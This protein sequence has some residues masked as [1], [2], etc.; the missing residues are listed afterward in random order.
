MERY[1]KMTHF[2]YGKYEKM[3]SGPTVKRNRLAKR[4]YVK[5][6]YVPDYNLSFVF[7]LGYSRDCCTPYNNSS[8]P[9]IYHLVPHGV[10]PNLP[11]VLCNRNLKTDPHY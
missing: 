10:A 2:K 8:E 11:S 3:P 6:I 7:S 4:L 9:N 5:L 1:E